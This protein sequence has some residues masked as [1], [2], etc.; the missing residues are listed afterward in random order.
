MNTGRNDQ[1]TQR[2][3]LQSVAILFIAA[4]IG[5][6]VNQ[7]RTDSLALV[8]DWSI[9]AQ[10]GEGPVQLMVISLDKAREAFLSKMAVFLDARPAEVYNQG[11]IRGARSLPWESVDEYFDKVMTGIP[12][13]ALIITYCDGE[14]CSLSK[15]LAKELFFR[16]YE[17]VHVLVNGWS[18]WKEAG[19]PVEEG[20][21][22]YEGWNEK[23]RTW[24]FQGDQG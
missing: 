14:S 22:A 9:Q 3:L 24:R 19:L 21:N 2:T 1:I 11:H 20:T 12:R 4:A 7:F 10:L 23:E 18:R 6:M 15:D 17:N 13:D 8:S 16:G 5:L